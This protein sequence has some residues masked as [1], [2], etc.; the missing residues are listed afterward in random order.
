[1]QRA[2]HSQPEP[3]SATLYFVVFYA[4]LLSFIGL[5]IFFTPLIQLLA[6]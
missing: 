3:H 2:S 1:M 5:S 4:G 6:D